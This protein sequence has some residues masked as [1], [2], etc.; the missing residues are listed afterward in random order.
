MKVRT[1]LAV[2]ALLPLAFGTVSGCVGWITKRIEQLQE[3]QAAENHKRLVRRTKCTYADRRQR[4]EEK[5]GTPIPDVPCPAG[6]L[7]GFH[8]CKIDQ[9]QLRDDILTGMLYLDYSEE[10]CLKRAQES[11]SSD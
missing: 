9:S 11:S 7:D 8:V 6:R 2:L 10:Q 5:L 4:A 3:Q 1:V